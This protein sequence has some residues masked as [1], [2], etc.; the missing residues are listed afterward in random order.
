MISRVK[1]AF[2]KALF[3]NKC[4]ACG[5]F[6]H[7]DERWQTSGHSPDYFQQTPLELVFR[8]EMS[9]F[10][11]FDC[12]RQFTPLEP[13]FCTQCGRM[14]ASRVSDNH[15]CEKCIKKKK[16]YCSARSAGLFSSAFMEIIHGFKY[17]G[18]L[19]FAEPL[20]RILFATFIK[21]FNKSLID[22]IIPVPLHE[23]KLKQRGFNQAL[24][25]LR[26]WPK[27]ISGMF[28]TDI[29]IDLRG[30]ILVRKKKTKPQTGLGKE[31]RKTNIKGA[32]DVKYP[33]KIQ[34]RRI[35]IVDDVYTTGA[36]T[37]ECAKTLIKH[38]AGE[39]HVLTLARVE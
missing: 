6:F 26:K 18:K 4:Q 3:P 9:P 19:Q 22:V 8:K 35:L 33:K 25:M 14:F 1:K 15:Q 39:V 7:C 37:E 32:F 16:H 24:Q 11:C 2:Q 36:T 27:L 29:C 21:Y 17:T 31:S 20:G 30:E 13:P 23:S 12:L 28:A 38:G 10:L 34:K 5:L